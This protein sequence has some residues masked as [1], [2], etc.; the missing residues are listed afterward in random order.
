M[1]HDPAAENPEY[2]VPGPADAECPTDIRLPS[3]ADGGMFQELKLL[4]MGG[5]GVV[6]EADDPAL[7]R[8]VALKML[9]ARYRDDPDMI[10]KFIKEARITAKIDHPNIV[11][12]H[13][14]GI[15]RECGAYFSMRRIRGETLL[16]VLRK[17]REGD[18]EARRLY[19]P[20]RLLNVFVS[21]CNGVAAA[22]RRGIL[23]CDLKPSNIMIGEI[24]EVWVM[25]WGLARETAPEDGGPRPAEPAGPAEPTGNAGGTPAFMAPELLTGRVAAPDVHT[26][27]YAL[28]AIL[29]CILTW[30]DAP[31]DLTLSHDDLMHAAAA[32]KAL[33]LHAPDRAQVLQVE[34]AAICR[35][36]M[37]PD[38]EKRY[39]D[40]TEL[41]QDLHNY[42]DGFP[43]SAYSP[44]PVYRLLK[45]CRRRPLV[46]SV[47]LAAL[48]MLGVY[49]VGGALLNY[50]ENR[51][52]ARQ[53][54][55][56]VRTADEHIR[57]AT[58]LWRT[59][60]DG[61][62]EISPLN[63][64]QLEGRMNYNANL[65]MMETFAAFDAASGLPP[66]AMRR[67]AE[68]SGGA[69]CKRLLQMQIRTAA[70]PEPQL[71][72]VE[73]FEHR[74][75]RLFD[76]CLRHDPELQKLVDRIRK[77]TGSLLVRSPGG[78][79]RQVLVIRPDGGEETLTIREPQKLE[80]ASGDVT[81]R[82][83]GNG[84]AF[85]RIAP[86][87]AAAFTLP[88]KSGVPGFVTVPADHWFVSI[89]GVG[90]RLKLLA[91]YRI[92]ATEVDTDA[93]KQVTTALPAG[94][95]GNKILVGPNGAE[96]YCR[97]LRE[98]LHANVRL[99][100]E[101]EL[102]KSLTPGP[103]PLRTFYGA[104]P[105][106]PGVRLFIR[107]ANGRIALFDPAT[108]RVRPADPDSQAAL[109]VVLDNP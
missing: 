79:P 91:E 88:T 45:L 38:R 21:C 105:P 22:H 31:F 50:T 25:D 47:A 19:T 11:A 4:G 24:G 37:A 93:F 86:G 89:P 101:M 67:F 87:T 30:R 56:S 98:R 2:T 36:A 85:F 81:L 92:S 90:E 23:H 43:V 78:E 108:G 1:N 10:A 69:L 72:A 13:R 60:T 73:R 5:M 9:R 12:V 97:M 18:P 84:A 39:S 63:T 34:L 75:R 3:D 20:R 80:F 61:E 100:G 17:L 64:S 28:G 48:L 16:A 53:V 54:G 52:R 7:E 40:V 95:L 41:L 33:P 35:K 57:A 26:E 27:I 104:V 99:P 82:P 59:L 70:D 74:S 42:M 71:A 68:N 94:R 107:R 77:G 66:A 103:S 65:A 109:R 29:H 51:A 8:K 15:N 106:E 6:Y 76:L 58:R 83:S 102:R 44:N 96:L 55:F 14:L 32:G 62:R 49:R 46:P